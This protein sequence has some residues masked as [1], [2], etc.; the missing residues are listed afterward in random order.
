MYNRTDP[1]VYSSRKVKRSNWE[2]AVWVGRVLLLRHVNGLLLT[3]HCSVGGEVER[4]GSE[5]L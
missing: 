5:K 1:T 2:E 3:V 4:R